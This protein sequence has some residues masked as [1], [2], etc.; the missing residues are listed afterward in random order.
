MAASKEFWKLRKWQH[1]PRGRGR[2][3]GPEK[4]MPRYWFGA[5]RKA[6]A[7][8]ETKGVDTLESL[9]DNRKVRRGPLVA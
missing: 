2:R 9:A 6:A 3:V 7:K 1:P 8:G 5:R 4:A